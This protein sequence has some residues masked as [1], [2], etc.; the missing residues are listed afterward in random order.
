M[1]NS[2]WHRERHISIHT[3]D[4]ANPLNIFYSQFE[5]H[6]INLG[7]KRFSPSEIHPLKWL[8]IMAPHR[9]SLSAR[10]AA[11]STTGKKVKLTNILGSGGGEQISQNRWLVIGDQ[12][13]DSD[14]IFQGWEEVGG[15]GWDP[16]ASGCDHEGGAWPAQD[17]HHHPHLHH[18]P[19][20]H[21][22][23]LLLNLITIMTFSQ[24]SF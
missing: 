20:R 24:W 14:D 10:K 13:D 9:L 8:V 6:I 16:K 19:S 1:N 7:A 11:W 18:H 5:L 4:F 12:T 22:R 3:N 17:G 23:H 15:G 21:V 2:L